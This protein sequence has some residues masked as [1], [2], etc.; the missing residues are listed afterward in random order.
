MHFQKRRTRMDHSL[1]HFSGLRLA[2]QDTECAFPTTPVSKSSPQG[3]KNRSLFRGRGKFPQGLPRG[4][5]E[6]SKQAPR[7]QAP[8]EANLTFCLVNLETPRGLQEAPK[9]PPRGLQE[10][11]KSPFSF[12]FSFSFSFSLQPSAFSLQPSAFSLQPS[13]FSLQPLAS[14][15]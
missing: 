9:R 12:R 15:L 4:A 10:P 6:A 8:Q 7:G 1:K 2:R 14:S 5:Q 3:S 13:A 11:S